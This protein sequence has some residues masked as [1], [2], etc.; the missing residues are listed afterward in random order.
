MQLQLKPYQPHYKALAQLG[1]PI[2]IGQ[3][4]SIVLGFADTLM[5]GRHS[6]A[7]LGAAAF[8]NNMFVLVLIFAMG[9]AYGL[10]PIVGSLYGREECGKIGAILKNSLVANTASGDGTYGNNDCSVPEFGQSRTTRRAIATDASL[11][12]RQ[13]DFSAFRNVVQ[14]LQTAL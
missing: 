10:T 5:I 9:F 11:L 2:I 12:H 7:E 13:S 6:T 8:V 4:G 1:I 14:Y 3:I